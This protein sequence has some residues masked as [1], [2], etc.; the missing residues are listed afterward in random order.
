MRLI[1][2]LFLTA[3][4][5]TLA[6]GNDEDPADATPERDASDDAP[7]IQSGTSIQ[8]RDGPIEGDTSGG[9]RRFRG[10]P[11]A[12]PPI[13]AL[14]WK[15]PEAVEPWT[16]VLQ[17]TA[18]ASACAQPEWLQGPESLEEDCLYLNV[19][20]PDPAPS[21]PL[22]VMVW[23]PGGGN[24]NGSASDDSPLSGGTT[25]Y[26]GQDLAASR[27]VVVV[28]IN[29][30]VGVMGFFAHEGLREEGSISG[31]QGLLDQRA[32]PHSAEIPRT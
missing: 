10:I 11:Y 31:N 12:K 20:T 25:I 23:L 19:W 18:F 24:Q 5:F 7:S 29:Y 1:R 28:T 17:T 8:L 21:A 26:D 30:R 4:A 13:G 16:D 22:P 6:C 3:G 2:L 27:N 14:R 15:P 32:A 9:A